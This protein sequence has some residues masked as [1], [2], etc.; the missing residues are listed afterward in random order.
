VDDL[1]TIKCFAE[2]FLDIAIADHWT[3]L[4][5]SGYVRQAEAAYEV[6]VDH[7][8]FI[9]IFLLDALNL[10]KHN[11]LHIDLFTVIVR[12]IELGLG[13]VAYG[14]HVESHWGRQ[15]SHPPRASVAAIQPYEVYR[16]FLCWKH[17][18]AAILSANQIKRTKL[19]QFQASRPDQ[20]Q[21]LY[22]G[23]RET[24]QQ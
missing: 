19:H 15:M 1:A 22:F 11:S 18:T 20:M 16:M 21:H 4:F 7:Q 24:G 2:T 9:L 23:G 3:L 8:P 10:Q 6:A 12:S 5:L 17:H 13:V 14:A